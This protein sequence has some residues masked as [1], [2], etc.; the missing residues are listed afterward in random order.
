MARQGLTSLF[1]GLGNL[2]GVK[3][4]HLTADLQKRFRGPTTSQERAS[5]ELPRIGSEPVV[6]PAGQALAARYEGPRIAAFVPLPV[7]VWPHRLDRAGR[8]TRKATRA[9]DESMERVDRRGRR[10]YVGGLSVLPAKGFTDQTRPCSHG[11]LTRFWG[12]G[13]ARCPGNSLRVTIPRKAPRRPLS[14]PPVASRVSAVVAKA[15]AIGRQRRRWTTPWREAYLLPMRFILPAL[16]QIRPTLPRG[17][18]WLHE[19]KLDGWRV[20]AHKQDSG[21]ALYSKRGLDLTA[22]FRSIASAVAA[23]PALSVILDGEIVALAPE[24]RPQRARSQG[25]DRWPLQLP[26]GGT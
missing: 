16:P 21:V 18:V 4:A 1:G 10:S 6:V 13:S 5:S 20:Q 7:R 14:R 11:G 12:L 24:G 2:S 8:G 3:L 23:M 26:A 9:V 25:R 22:R 15:P 19:P 17:D